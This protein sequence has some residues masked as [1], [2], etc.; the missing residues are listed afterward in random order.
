MP[1]VVYTARAEGSRKFREPETPDS[2]FA[3]SQRISRNLAP[4]SQFQ[5]AAPSQVE[6]VARRY[7]VHKGFAFWIDRH[8]LL[9][10]VS[11][12]PS[13]QWRPR[14]GF[15]FLMRDLVDPLHPVIV[16]GDSSADCTVNASQAILNAPWRVGKSSA[17]PGMQSCCKHA[18]QKATEKVHRCCRFVRPTV[19]IIEHTEYSAWRW[20]W[21]QCFISSVRVWS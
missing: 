21:M 6:K 7:R 5:H 20:H 1:C 18:L 16:H 15:R 10:V 4:A 2:T 8:A 12:L 11:Y 19:E 17:P 14:E 3:L 9:P 13:V